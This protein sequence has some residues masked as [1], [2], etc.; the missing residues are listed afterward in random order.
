MQAALTGYFDQQEAGIPMA[1]DFRILCGFFSHPK[2]LKLFARHGSDGLIAL[3]MLWEWA[4]QYRSKGVLYDMSD[5]DILL[6][7]RMNSAPADM[8]D[9][10]LSDLVEIRWLDKDVNG[11]YSLHNWAERQPWVFNEEDRKQQAKANAEAGWEKRRKAST[12]GKPKPKEKKKEGKP[13]PETPANPGP[14]GEDAGCDAGGTPDGDAP[15]LSSPILSKK[16]KGMSGLASELARLLW[17]RVKANNPKAKEPKLENWAKELDKAI[18]LDGRTPE[19][20]KDMIEWSADNPF[21]RATIL[22]AESLRRNFDKVMAQVRRARGQP[23]QGQAQP[24][25]TQGMTEE[26][27]QRRKAVKP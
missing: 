17:E 15:F 19:D 14:A 3:Q 4:A 18:R 10:F 1:T 8:R 23:E 2:T 21:W 12:K 16:E 20:L 9:R 7:C 26:E 24:E 27:W 5:E 13:R 22:G 6:A 25:E 11:V